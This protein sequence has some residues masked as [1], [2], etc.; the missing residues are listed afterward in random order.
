MIKPHLLGTPTS[1]HDGG[2]V[3][4]GATIPSQKHVSDMCEFW[5]SRVISLGLVGCMSIALSLHLRQR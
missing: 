2:D 3:T 5:Y 4:G 1:S